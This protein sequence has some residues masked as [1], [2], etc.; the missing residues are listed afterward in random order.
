MSGPPVM[1]I[2]AT[3]AK[4]FWPN[5]D[6][7][8]KCVQFGADS[9]PCT[10]VI[11]VVTDTKRGLTEQRHSPRYY[12]SLDQTAQGI[13]ERYFFVRSSRVN[14]ALVDGIRATIASVAP[15]APFVEAFPL[16]RVLDSY[17]QQWRLGTTAFVAFGVLATAVAAIGLFGVISFGVARRERE[18]GIRRALGEPRSSILRRVVVSATG[19]SIV[20]LIAGGLLAI[21]LARKLHE[22]LFNPNKRP[23]QQRIDTA[24]I[25]LRLF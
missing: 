7:I 15:S 10:T 6:P 23:F 1:V 19:K 14:P 12:L 2:D 13:R 11:G 4:T 3:M 16:E 9:L 17:T 5:D 25:D 20:G 8:G 18:F 21:V 22:L 24:S